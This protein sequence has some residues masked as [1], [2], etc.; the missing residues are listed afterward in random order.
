LRTLTLIF[1]ALLTLFISLSSP[2]MQ[3]NA[4][5]WHSSIAA[6]TPLALAAPRQIAAEWGINTCR[7][8][9]RMA[10]IEHINYRH[11]FNSGFEDVS[12]LAEGTSARQ[13]QGY[14]DD[15]LR[16]GRS[17]QTERTVSRLNTPLE[18]LLELTR[19][20]ML[21]LASASPS[22]TATSRLHSQSHEHTSPLERKRLSNPMGG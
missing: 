6:K 5:F 15:A 19:P 18:E 21:P 1:S 22:A 9:G 7:H 4:D 16:Y 14:V 10:A 12:R 11:A 20:G 3:R 17:R 8:G 2:A 13:I